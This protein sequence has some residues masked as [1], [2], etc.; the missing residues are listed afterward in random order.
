MDNF[1]KGIDYIGVCVVFFCYDG[2]GNFIM[3][4]R[5][6]NAR[7]E[8]GRYDI[9]GGAVEFGQ[10]ID[11]TLRKEIKEEYNVDVIDYDFLGFRDVHRDKDGVKTHW[12]GLDFKVLVNPEGLRINEPHKFD[13]IAWFTMQTIPEESKVHSQF[14]HFLKK[15]A[16]QL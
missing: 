12:I 1:K 13:D 9:G 15:Y 11:E 2:K 6:V 7:D 14:P 3:A 10:T 16:K 8:N 5:S 4:K